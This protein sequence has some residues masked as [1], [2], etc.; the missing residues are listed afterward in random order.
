MQRRS[1]RLPL[2]LV[3]LVV[4][5]S[6]AAA[7]DRE[8]RRFFEK[9]VEK[10]NDPNPNLPVKY[11]L[12]ALEHARNKVLRTNV[13]F[14]LGRLH[15]SRTGDF[16]EAEKYYEMVIKENIG[17]RDNTLRKIKSDAFRNLGNLIYASK[18]DVNAALNKY[19]ASHNTYASPETAD[20]LSQFLYRIGRDPKKS[21]AARDRQLEAATKLAREA[22]AMD[23]KKKH[24]KPSET[25]RYQLQL[26]ICLLAA[27]KEEEA[28]A[29]ESELRFDKLADNSL[30]QQAILMALRGE[31]P[32]KIAETLHRTLDPRP[33]PKTRN[34]LRHFIRTEPDFASF[35]GREDWKDLVSD[36][37]LTAASE[38]EGAAEQSSPSSRPVK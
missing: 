28:K 19:R 36:E 1:S 24:R 16:A 4:C 23:A 33:T 2:A 3:T 35:L 38:G 29:V 22:I 7:G 5:A 15:H 17:V 13:L 25:A 37:P 21:Q 18:G 10:W 31:D 12:K 32:S 27:G 20:T 6:P 26:L 9:A 14:L 8:A 11:A 30:Y 34:D